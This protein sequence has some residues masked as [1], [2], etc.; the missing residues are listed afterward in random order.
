VPRP[1]EGG[2]SRRERDHFHATDRNGPGKRPVRIVAPTPS[3]RATEPVA[4]SRQEEHLPAADDFL[5]NSRPESAR[6]VPLL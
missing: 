5:E 6:F 3:Y 1:N 4:G 2:N